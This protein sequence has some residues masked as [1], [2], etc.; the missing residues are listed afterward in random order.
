MLANLFV[1]LMVFKFFG[2]SLT[3]L[4]EVAFLLVTSTGI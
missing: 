1:L 2:P 3:F 4:T